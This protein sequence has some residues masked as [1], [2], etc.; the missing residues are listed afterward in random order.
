MVSKGMEKVSERKCRFDRIERGSINP[1]I[2][3]VRNIHQ[4]EYLLGSYQFPQREVKRKKGKKFDT[5]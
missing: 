3:V 4:Y 1:D 2:K 5:E